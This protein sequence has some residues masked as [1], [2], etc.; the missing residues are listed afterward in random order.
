VKCFGPA[1]DGTPR[2]YAC[3]SDMDEPEF[4]KQAEQFVSFIY[5]KMVEFAD[6]I[7]R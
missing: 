4:K 6:R 3:S 5:K 1:S 7:F 2:I